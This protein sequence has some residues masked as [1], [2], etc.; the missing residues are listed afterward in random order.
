MLFCIDKSDTWKLTT[1]V[2]LQFLSLSILLQKYSHYKLCFWKFFF[3]IIFFSFRFL[4][5]KFSTQFVSTLIVAGIILFQVRLASV[6][7][8]LLH[9]CRAV[10]FNFNYKIILIVHIFW[11]VN[12]CC[13]FAGAN[14][15]LTAPRRAEKSGFYSN[16]T[17]FGFCTARA[18]VMWSSRCLAKS[19][20]FAADGARKLRL[21][22]RYRFV[23]G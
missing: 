14:A 7:S 15:V 6:W 19:A 9:H 16:W 23:I 5:F 17:V 1:N 22:R 11:L 12:S 18:V 3:F 4:D 20:Y 13:M 2:F 8:V 10:H 21:R